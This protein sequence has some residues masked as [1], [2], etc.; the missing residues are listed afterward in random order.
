MHIEISQAGLEAPAVCEAVLRAL[1][2]WF[3]IE[4]A[5]VD[6]VRDAGRL[7]GYVA[8]VDGEPAAY[9]AL[10]AHRSWS[11]EIH[12]MGVLPAYHRH[13]L[14]RRLVEAAEAAARADGFPYLTVKTLGPSHGDPG[15]AATRRFYAAVGFQALEELHGL[16]A[17]GNPTLIMLKPIH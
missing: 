3:G 12:V 15:Y 16:W 9:M 6:Y 10:A 8:R 17:P 5:L 13:G 7:P 2:Q 1:P 4:E 11:L 14:G